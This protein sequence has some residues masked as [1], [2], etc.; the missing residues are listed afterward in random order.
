MNIENTT[1][2]ATM[3]ALLAEHLEYIRHLLQRDVQFQELDYTIMV[4]TRLMCCVKKNTVDYE[5]GSYNAQ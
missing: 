2:E 4:S 3:I 5:G 1:A